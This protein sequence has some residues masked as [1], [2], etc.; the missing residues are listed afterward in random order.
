MVPADSTDIHNEYK[1]LLNELKQYNPELLHK[2]R[3]LAITKTDMLDEELIAE[4]KKDLPAIPVV[5]ISA[6]AQIGLT[7]LKDMIW[8]QLNND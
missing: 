3:I 5:F 1:V 6:I 4:I 8:E 7:D 2:D